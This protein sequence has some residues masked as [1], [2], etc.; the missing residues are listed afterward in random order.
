MKTQKTPQIKRYVLIDKDD[1][2]V[3]ETTSFNKII[4]IANTTQLL[5]IYEVFWIGERLDDYK[6]AVWHE[7][8]SNGSHIAVVCDVDTLRPDVQSL[9]VLLGDINYYT[10][11]KEVKKEL[12]DDLKK[13]LKNSSNKE[14]FNKKIREL[15]KLFR[16]KK[17]DK[18]YMCDTTGAIVKKVG[19]KFKRK[20]SFCSPKQHINAVTIR[21]DCCEDTIGSTHEYLLANLT[22]IRKGGK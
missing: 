21:H 11:R 22:K 1:K 20:I 17:S 15:K 3:Y 9:Q 13:R 16:I 19:K 12:L 14:H 18:L 10:S 4:E 6:V 7:F 5:K 8:R 2:S